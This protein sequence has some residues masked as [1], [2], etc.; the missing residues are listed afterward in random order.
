M[1][2]SN[3]NLPLFEKGLSR[4]SFFI[5]E[6]N[7]SFSCFYFFAER[8]PSAGTEQWFHWPLSKDEEIFWACCSRN[9]PMLIASEHFR[10][11]G[12]GGRVDFM[13]DFL[14]DKSK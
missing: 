11:E 14:K 13:F 3:V 5:L 4:S 8:E 7:S 12:G 10:G 2:Q 6:L 1:L 9:L